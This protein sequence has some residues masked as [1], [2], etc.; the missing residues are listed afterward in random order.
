MKAERNFA[1]QSLLATLVMNALLLAAIYLL[2]RTALLPTLQMLPLLAVA[3]LA[4]LALWAVIRYLAAR[5]VRRVEAEIGTAVAP[6]PPAEK[7]LQPPVTTPAPVVKERRA[8]AGAAQ[9]L[10]ILQREGRLIDFLQE[11][12][13]SFEDAQIGAAVRSVHAGCKQA[14]DEHVQL[15]PIY[16]EPE[17]SRVTVEP[18]FDAYAVRLSG[19]V[20]GEPPFHGTLQHRGWRAANIDLPQAVDAERDET[21]IAAA[22]V[23]IA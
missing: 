7:P 20:S 1:W 22:E 3:L 13:A 9:M 12:L 5:L 15:E 18:G 19:S 8:E 21:I 2:V 23:E 4:T 17:G 16:T 10:A 6:A 14:L 11:D